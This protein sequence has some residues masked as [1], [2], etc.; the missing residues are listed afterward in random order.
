MCVGSDER[1][2][3]ITLFYITL[4]SPHAH[5]FTLNYK[6]HTHTLLHY[7]TK[8]TRADTVIPATPPTLIVLTVGEGYDNCNIHRSRI[9]TA[10]TTTA[11]LTPP[12]GMPRANNPLPLG[13]EDHLGHHGVAGELGHA[14]AQLGEL[15]QVVEGAQRVQLLQR[16]HQR[17]MGRGVHEVKVDQ[18]VDPQRLQAHTVV[19][20]W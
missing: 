6:A 4:Q 11:A 12:S 14:A 7:I 18:V 20:W 17:L 8:P 16:Q 19:W 15:S 1:K 5:S 10:R 3:T 9:S 2:P 13:G